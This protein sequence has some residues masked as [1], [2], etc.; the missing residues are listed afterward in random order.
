[1]ISR[2]S[3]VSTHAAKNFLI[4]PSPQAGSCVIVTPM[5]ELAVERIDHVSVIVTDVA[6]AVDFYTRVLRLTEIPRPPTFDFPGAWLQA[7][8]DVIHLLGKPAPDCE[9][10]R[11]FCLW[12]RDVHSAARHVTA[13]GGQVQWHARHKI[14]GVDRFFTHDPDGNR[15]ELQGPEKVDR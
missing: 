14:P 13:A 15:I 5:D 4:R 1:M 7:G 6:R 2:L 8:R 9:S 12:V 3:A 11:H 10:Q